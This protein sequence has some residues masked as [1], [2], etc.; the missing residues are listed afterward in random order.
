MRLQQLQLILAVMQ[1]G[2]LR[3]AA[4]MLNL[5]QPALTKSLRQ[6]EEEL[7][8]P[9][10]IRS[11]RGMRLAPAGELLA[12]RAANVMREIQQARDDI[13]W[14]SRQGTGSVRLGL[15]PGAAIHLTPAAIARFE[16]RWPQVR[17]HVIDTLYPTMLA[18]LRAGEIDLAIGPLP[19]GDIGHDLRL[20]PLFTSQ[21]VIA[22]RDGHPRVHARH[23]ADLAEAAWVLTGPE[24]GP[25]D[26]AHLDFARVGLPSPHVRLV[27]ESFAT[28]LALLPALDVLA[29]MPR[30]FF[31][32][33]GPRLGLR[34]LAIQDRLPCPTIHILWRADGPLPIPAQRLRDVFIHE[35]EVSRVADSPPTTA[36]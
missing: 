24:G 10:M 36:Q 14:H 27:C 34:M 13:A 15:S 31:D 2:S 7:G 1:A 32:R 16:S 35:A 33:Y 6:L 26:P 20:Q 25:G 28:V 9:L 29:V 17:V 23:L 18:Q 22:A 11:P 8:T 4:D 3:A 21:H 5:S 12:A 19:D 30:R